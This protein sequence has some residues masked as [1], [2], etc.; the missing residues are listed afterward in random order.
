MKQYINGK[1]K[2]HSGGLFLDLNVGV[3]YNSV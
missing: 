3:C 2:A 1:Q